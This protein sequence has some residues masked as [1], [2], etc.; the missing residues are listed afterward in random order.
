[1]ARYV[2]VYIY[3]Y[4]NTRPIFSRSE[5]VDLLSLQSS[6]HESPKTPRSDTHTHTHTLSEQYLFCTKMYH[7]SQFQ[8]CFE[9]AYGLASNASNNHNSN[10][11]S[12]PHAMNSGSSIYYQVP[13]FSLF[14]PVFWP[15]DR[16][17]SRPWTLIL[18]PGISSDRPRSTPCPRIPYLPD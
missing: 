1:M 11:N 16:S 3:I 14:D 5:P 15:F 6:S 7:D 18:S 17:N 10:I 8:S 13:L 9:A 4:I 2:P 12:L